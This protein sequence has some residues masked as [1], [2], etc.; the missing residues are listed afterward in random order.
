[1][2][3]GVVNSEVL[4][5]LALYL[6]ILILKNVKKNESLSKMIV[7]GT[8]VGDISPYKIV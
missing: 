6:E 3:F 1:M 7:L 4:E 5:C 8:H 2:C